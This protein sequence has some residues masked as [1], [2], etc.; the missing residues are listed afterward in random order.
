M[1]ASQAP[2]M[3]GKILPPASLGSVGLTQEPL[4]LS[5][6]PIMYMVGAG[7]GVEGGGSSAV[8]KVLDLVQARCIPGCVENVYGQIFYKQVLTNGVVIN[9]VDVV[10]A[11]VM[12][13]MGSHVPFETH[14]VSPPPPPFSPGAL[15]E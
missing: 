6:C 3:C 9:L 11:C 12:R 7:G 10:V 2:T 13:Y 14:S 1:M 5:L 15:T 8:C 4:P